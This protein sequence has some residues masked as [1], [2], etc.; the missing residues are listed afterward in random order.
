MRTET[1][2]KKREKGT[3]GRSKVRTETTEQNAANSMGG[4]RD[5]QARRS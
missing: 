3:Q 2:S 5:N 4:G 1:L